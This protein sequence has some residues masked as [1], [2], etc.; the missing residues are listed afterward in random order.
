ML[1]SK[2]PRVKRGPPPKKLIKRHKY[3]AC[4]PELI[5]D[6]SGRCAYSMQHHSR[7]GSL[8][9]DHFD[10]RRK[11]DVTQDYNNLFPASRHCNGKK[12]DI[13]PTKAEQ[14]AGCRFLNPCEE[15]DYGEQIFEDPATHRLHGTTP[16]AVWHIRVCGLNADHLIHERARRSE[17]WATIKSTPV[18]RIKSD[19]PDLL[20]LIEMFREELQLMIPEVPSG[21]F[22]S[23]V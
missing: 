2:K 15:M 9:V 18:R 22:G 14:S 10:P 6:F 20:G 3:A 11:K 16:A 7:A 13:W 12:S 4:L 23:I 5:R 19:H 8:E 21:P 17:Y 1:S